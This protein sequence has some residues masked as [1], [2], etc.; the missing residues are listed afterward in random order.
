MIIIFSGYNQR[1]VIS[2]IRTLEKNQIDS[3]SIIAVNHDPILLTKYRKKVSYVR[4][5]KALD[6][7]EIFFALNK[8][9]NSVTNQKLFIAPSTEALNRFLLQ[10][11]TQFENAG[12]IIPLVD[13]N[14]YEKISDKKKFSKLCQ[15]YGILT[16][17]EITKFKPFKPVVAKPNKYFSSDGKIYSPQFIFTESEFDDFLKIHVKDDFTYQEFLNGGDSFY[18][19]FY[20]SKKGNVYSFSQ[21]NLSQQSA[22]KSIIAA[23]SASY[24]KNSGIVNPYINLFKQEKFFGL[25]M[26]EIRHY[27]NNYYMI[28][29][30]PRFWGPSQLFCDA[31]YN[32]FEFMLKD[33]ELIEKC[34]EKVK[35]SVYY[36][37]G[38]DGIKTVWHEAG[39]NF[40]ENNKEK[41][42]ESEIYKREDTMDI[43]KLEKLQRLYSST[44][45]HSNYQVLPKKLESLIDSSNLKIKSRYEIERM[46]YIKKYVN[47]DGLNVLDIGGNTGFFTFEC[48]D[49]S[50]NHVNYFEGNKT[51]AEFVSIA[52]ELL[53]LK[54]KITVSPQYYLF[55]KKINCD[56]I[57]NLNVVHHLGD[58]FYKC[59]AKSDAKEKML[60][61]LNSL[62]DSANIM[63]FQM[64][65]N[66][67]GDP[68]CCLFDRGLKK[69]VID[70]ITCGT[71]KYWKI[72]SIGI[73][74]KINDSVV[75]EDLNEKNIQRQDELGEFLNRPLFIM[76]S[77]NH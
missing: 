50:A 49:C 77:I 11:R 12:F 27:N 61:C 20:F 63:I 31:E 17:K 52:A 73:A 15:A 74:E 70:F 67:K 18:L 36:W 30:N 68:N 6:S 53:N 45:K 29:A 14:L 54:D 21:K 8:I 51:H 57:F 72:I 58:D 9:K 41:F 25:V 37:Q 60:D 22:G 40:F 48:L 4:Q 32:F 59:K 75:Y 64:G 46:N 76:E 19:L 44:S 5:I 47:F 23:I 2:F 24:H 62:S 43:Y 65:F 66:W 13:E 10:N 16:P 7:E 39:L 56:I 33:Y 28:E 69:E 3:Y 71:K 26:V 35:N 34:S 38:G 1:A 42:L 55:D